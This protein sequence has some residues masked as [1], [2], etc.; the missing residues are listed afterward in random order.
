[1]KAAVKERLVS[2]AG[3]P[4][5]R[6]KAMDGFAPPAEGEGAGQSGLDFHP[7]HRVV[8]P[9]GMG[10]EKQERADLPGSPV[11]V[12]ISFLLGMPPGIITE[13]L[14]IRLDENQARKLSEMLVGGIHIARVDE[15]PK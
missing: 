14:S 9:I 13:E 8:T 6:R 12:R 11:E 5:Q 3:A 10:V 1:M 4:K 15:I 2:R 7:P